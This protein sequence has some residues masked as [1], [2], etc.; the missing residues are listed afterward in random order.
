MTARYHFISGL[1]RSGSTL[2]A[3]ILKQNPRFQAAMTSPVASMCGAVHKKMCGGEFDVFFDDEKRVRILRSVIDSYYSFPH[4]SQ[5]IFDTNR[6][7]TGRAALLG[8]LYPDARI[9]CCVRDIGWIIDSYE[10]LLARQPLQLSRTFSSQPGTSIYARADHLMQSE[11]GLIGL[12]WSNLREAW[13]SEQAKRLIIVPYDR[14]ARE[15]D[16]VLRKLYSH[17]NEPWFEHDFNQVKYDEPDYDAQMGMPGLHRVRSRVSHQDRQPCIP[18][19]L[20]A[21]YAGS[22]FWTKP[23]LNVRSVSIL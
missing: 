22:H 8:A 5:V 15:P 18:P 12:P 13:F 20:F 14:L 10:R 11:S 17:L 9:I 2:L 23:E 6:T 21:K 3:A 4:E 16:A 19:D 1:P 7:W